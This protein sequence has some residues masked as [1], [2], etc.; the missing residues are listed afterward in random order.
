MGAGCVNRGMTDRKASRTRLWGALLGLVL[1]GPACASYIPFTDRA[2]DRY[3]LGPRDR[4]LLQYFVS[5][6]FTLRRDTTDTSAHITPGGT[7]RYYKGRQIEEI[8]VARHTP[9]VAV[10]HRDG[11]L[12]LSFVSGDE[13]SPIE[14]AADGEVREADYPPDSRR[15]AEPPEGRRFAEPPGGR[16]PTEPTDGAAR[17]ERYFLQGDESH[18]VRYDGKTWSVHYGSRPYLLIRGRD[19]VDKSTQVRTLPGR[20]VGK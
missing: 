10:G 7:I 12:M 1:C 8:R 18:P 2:V 3:E 9:C 4:A 15:F 20:V 6:E 11:A 19:I 14:F 5:D 17:G 16:R 13:R